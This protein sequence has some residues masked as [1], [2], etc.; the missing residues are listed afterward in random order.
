MDDTMPDIVDVECVDRNGKSTN[1][2]RV[3]KRE[4]RKLVKNLRHKPFFRWNRKRVSW[5][6]LK[7]F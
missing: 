2:Y 6:E 7:F 5:D 4:W 3:R 1:W